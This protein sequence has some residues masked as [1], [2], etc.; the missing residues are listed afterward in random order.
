VS[1]IDDRAVQKL[2]A[3]VGEPGPGDVLQ[4]R[5][6]LRSLIGEGGMGVVFS[7][8][9]RET[10]REVAVKVVRSGDEHAEMRLQR[11]A[12]VLTQLSHPA[13]V[14]YIAV[15]TRGHSHFLVMERL[16]GCSLA[17]K[18]SR[19]PLSVPDAVAIGR[20][21]AD[22][23]GAVHRLGLAHRDIKPSNI[24]LVDGAASGVRLLDFGLAKARSYPRVTKTGALVGTPGYMAPEQVRAAPD[25]GPLADV[26]ALG[27]VLF[28]CLTGRPAFAGE[29]DE[30]LLAQILI[31][32][33]PLVRELRFEVPAALEGLVVQM[34]SKQAAERPDCAQVAREFAGIEPLL[35]TRSPVDPARG[36]PS[37]ALTQGAIVAG[38]Y[39]VE[40]PLGE[41]GMGVVVAARH[42]ELGRRVAL[43][44]LRAGRGPTDEARFLREARA[45]AGLESEHV[46]RVLDVGRLESGAPYI[47]MEYLSGVDLS[48]HLKLHGPLSTQEA[49][50]Y[51]LEACEAIAEAHS[52]GIVH[53]DI[54]PSNLFLTSR[55]DGTPLVKVLDF[56]ISK[57]TQPLQ[58]SSRDAVSMTGASAVLGS[59]WYMSPEQLQDSKR[60]DARTDVWALGIVLHELLTGTPPFE[61]D[62]AVAV[63]A[64]IAASE[65]KRLRDVL[66]NA[67]AQLEAVVLRCLQKSPDKRFADVSELVA[68]LTPLSGKPLRK[69]AERG[70]RS[71]G[72]PPVHPRRRGHR[73]VQ[74]SPQAASI[75]A[76]VSSAL[77]N[78]TAS[79]NAVRPVLVGVGVCAAAL[80]AWAIVVPRGHRTS[81]ALPPA[82]SAVASAP[83]PV[84][85]AEPAYDPV[86]SVASVAAS[87]AVPI[88]STPPRAEAPVQ[89]PSSPAQ[90]SRTNKPVAAASGGSAAASSST[91]AAKHSAQQLDLRDPALEGR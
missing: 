40:F 78:A 50:L 25:V 29:S 24:Y 37:H 41:G 72:A 6:E 71:A 23:L 52:L 33:P 84:R 68:A 62:S 60:V 65:P 35:P 36:E 46:A 91:P 63:G 7:A 13:V 17:D 20:R 9:D 83:E 67:P 38:K 61:G 57:I 49:V 27:C 48:R 87:T 88:P 70:D 39:R 22:G 85:R 75:D 89:P 81:P 19:G 16:V 5:F 8:W 43:K 47:V 1:V 2:R 77:H 42:L 58:D 82:S 14:R 80:A 31:E 11:E 10:D 90:V 69:S 51:V 4:G 15:G 32:E 59:A 3:A 73:D 44:L 30:A 53:R 12:A 86:S 66:P 45:A 56:G 79:R 34:L 21:V 54:K 64:R 55:R 74:V 76:A 26:F 28:E 18:L